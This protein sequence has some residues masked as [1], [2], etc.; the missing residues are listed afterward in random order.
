MHTIYLQGYIH[1]QGVDDS[2]ELRVALDS[3]VPTLTPLLTPNIVP[4]KG[5]CGIH[6][7]YLAFSLLHKVS[8]GF[9]TASD[10]SSN[11]G[12]VSIF[13]SWFPVGIGFNY[14]YST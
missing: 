1:L 13:L 7:V 3:G 14:L 9:F 10:L 5:S 11:S 12:S 4:C 8:L 2:R 6:V